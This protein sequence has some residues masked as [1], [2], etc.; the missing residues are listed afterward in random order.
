[1]AAAAANVSL[2]GVRLGLGQVESAL[3]ASLFA[4]SHGPWFV[5]SVAEVY[6]WSAAGLTTEILLLERL[7]RSPRPF[8]ALSLGLTNGLGNCIHAFAIVSGASHLLLLPALIWR[9]RL[10]ASSLTLFV[11]GRIMGLAPWVILIGSRGGAATDLWQV[12]RAALPLDA[13]LSAA[14]PGRSQI[15]V[16]LGLTG[17]TL[18]SPVFILGVVGA[19]AACHT[20]G[21]S[22]G[23]WLIPLLVLYSLVGSRLTFPDQFMFFVPFHAVL[24]ALAMLGTR[25][26]VGHYPRRALFSVA[27]LWV[28]ALPAV[29]AAVPSALRALGAPVTLG[30][31][32]PF[33]DELSY[34]VRPWKFD[35]HSAERFARA[36][37]E[38][39]EHG[40]VIL[41]D[42]TALFPLLL[43]QSIQG[44]RPD[45]VVRATYEADPSLVLDQRPLYVVTPRR[46]YCPEWLLSAGRFLPAGPLYRVVL[47]AG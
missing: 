47:K 26:V 42:W 30:R 29:Y 4:L 44:L 3:V 36:A 31:A 5:A 34:W 7:S 22:L 19:V 12:I 14:L 24:A 11:V 28:A 46:P 41:A 38:G 18:L 33:R 6:G 2:L 43:V 23:R 45:V 27:I 16:S 35:D 1:M 21:R 13:G 32:L 15:L 37:L 20:N 10:R 9:G 17:L 8:H 39:V 40:S 25:V